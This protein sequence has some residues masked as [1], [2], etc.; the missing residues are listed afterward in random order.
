MTQPDLVKGD[1]V[2]ATKYEDG[3]PGDQWAVG[4]FD[5]MLAVA[6]GNRFM[7]V[8]NDGKQF[9]ANGFRRCEKISDAQGRWMIGRIPEIEAT[10]PH[11]G[12]DEDGQWHGRNIWDWLE[13]SP[14]ETGDDE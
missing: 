8:D 10:I 3:D 5:S 13:A 7:V 6:A 14:T 1:Y 2:L 12:Y 9:R 11:V 4:F